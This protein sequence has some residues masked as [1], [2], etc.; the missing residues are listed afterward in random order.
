MTGGLELREVC[1]RGDGGDVELLEQTVDAVL[2]ADAFL[3]QAQPGAHQI[4]RSSLLGADH[5]RRGDEAAAEQ[6]GEDVG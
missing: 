3:D 2:G 1:Q 4:A 6:Q 5:V